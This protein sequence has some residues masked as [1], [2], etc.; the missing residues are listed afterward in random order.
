MYYN[1]LTIIQFLAI[2]LQI[3]PIKNRSTVIPSLMDTHTHTHKYIYLKSLIFL[4]VHLPKVILINPKSE[5]YHR[6]KHK[7]KYF[8]ESVK[9]YCLN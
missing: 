1:S 7:I 3:F 2:F 8:L 4:Q 5:D 6:P 9:S